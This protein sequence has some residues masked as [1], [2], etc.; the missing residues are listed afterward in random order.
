MTI[1]KKDAKAVVLLS[2]GQDSTTV[3]GVALDTHKQVYALGFRYGQKHE[4]ELLQAQKIAKKHSV[5]FAV[6]DALALGAMV[7]SALVDEGSNVS[8]AHPYMKDVPASFVPARNALFLVLAH[9][10]A[11]E[12]GAKY[13]YGGMCQ[14][15][16]S[17]YPDCRET[18]VR[19]MET[20]LNVGYESDITVMTP[21]MHLSKG[22]TFHLAYDKGMLS[23]VIDLSHTCYN[24]VRNK[25]FA[26][27]RGCGECPACKLRAKGWEDYTSTGGVVV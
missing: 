4:V 2:G 20:A 9:A 14:T 27:G 11:Q 1:I 8:D 25:I 10:Y 13:I 5:P 24:G 26:W 6:V 7:T 18:F 17:G 23:D 22:E 3:L 21:L 12:I 19:A 15:D 16:Y